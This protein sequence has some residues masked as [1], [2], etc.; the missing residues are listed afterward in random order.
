MGNWLDGWYE[1]RSVFQ[2]EVSDLEKKI[3]LTSGE[4]T[5]KV[6]RQT[7]LNSKIE[8]RQKKI[9]EWKLMIEARREVIQDAQNDIGNFEHEIRNATTDIE[10]SQ[11]EQAELESTQHSTHRLEDLQR[12]KEQAQA[13]LDE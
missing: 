7:Q 8:K 5:H 6:E 12:E 1:R 2:A 13:R 4:D 10:D 11:R 9:E 3:A